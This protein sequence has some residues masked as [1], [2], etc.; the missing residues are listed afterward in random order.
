VCLALAVGR[1]GL[2]TIGVAGW[3]GV[4][5]LQAGWQEWGFI[6]RSVWLGGEGNLARAG[7]RAGLDTIGRAVLEGGLGTSGQEL[8]VAG[9][10]TL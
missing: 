6:A 10:W 5:G 8:E 9:M 2:R 7:G 3:E 4:L 1:A